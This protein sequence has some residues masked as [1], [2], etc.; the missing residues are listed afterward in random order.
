M[1]NYIIVRVTT[2][3]EKLE[4]SE[5][6]KESSESQGICLKSQRICNRIPKA[7][8]FCCLKLIFSQVEDSYFVNFLGEHVQTP[9]N[10]LGPIV[11][12][13]FGLEKSWKFILSGK[14]QP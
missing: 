3:L 5:N 10:G 4:K 7:R 11:E 1:H 8:E 13:N 9:L 2:D 12:L 14:W 6:L